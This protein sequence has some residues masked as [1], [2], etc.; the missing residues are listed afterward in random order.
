LK[1]TAQYILGVSK[2]V[3]TIKSQKSLQCRASEEE[4][5]EYQRK[6]FQILLYWPLTN[7]PKKHKKARESF[8]NKTT[9]REIAQQKV[10]KRFILIYLFFINSVEYICS[11]SIIKQ[12]SKAWHPANHF[13]CFCCDSCCAFFGAIKE[14]RSF[15]RFQ[16]G[17]P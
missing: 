12:H 5:D 16:Q 4:Q 8:N 17:R 7:H 13:Y 3:K 2:T 9:L 14:K 6:I 15:G 10:T 1:K 11:G